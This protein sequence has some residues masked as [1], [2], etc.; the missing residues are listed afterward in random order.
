[1]SIEEGNDDSEDPTRLVIEKDGETL[2]IWAV[3]NGE[4][5]FQARPH[6]RSCKKPIR[7]AIGTFLSRAFSDELSDSR[8]DNG[9]SEGFF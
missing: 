4:A 8:D 2:R 9:T 7:A 6:Y 5:I 1:M 3:L